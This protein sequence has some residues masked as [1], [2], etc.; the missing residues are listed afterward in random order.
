MSKVFI[1]VLASFLS[2]SKGLIIPTRTMSSAAFTHLHDISFASN[3][4]GYSFGMF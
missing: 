2:V 1:F 3:T 4:F